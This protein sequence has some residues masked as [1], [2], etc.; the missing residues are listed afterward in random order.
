[1]AAAIETPPSAMKRIAP[2]V[3]IAVEDEPPSETKPP[4]KPSTN[5]SLE[6]S[7][8]TEI[9]DRFGSES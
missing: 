6:K 4:L 3:D 2:E 7:F 9:V 1:M 5:N 8:S